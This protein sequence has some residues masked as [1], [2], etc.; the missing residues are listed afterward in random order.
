MPFDKGGT[1]PKTGMDSGG[2]IHYCLKQLGITVTSRGTN[3]L[4]KQIGGS[5]MPLAEA[6]RQNKVVPGAVLFY[7]DERGSAEYALICLDADWAV[8][9]SQQ[10]K[11]IHRTGTN[12]AS[13]RANTIVFVPGLDY[14]FATGPQPPQPPVNPHR[15]YLKQM[16]IIG[17]KKLRL[18]DA[19]DGKYVMQMQP[20]S[21]VDVHEIQGI[22]ARLT[23]HSAK[24]PKP[25]WAKVEFLQDYYASN[26]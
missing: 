19:P 8:Y 10:K 24:G 17:D 14:G 11:K 6:K 3:S 15:D 13:G 22:W 2:F 1:N 9:P 4:Y 23:Y 12:L 25:G 21:I 26:A 20:G 7:V 16:I 18:R 5:A